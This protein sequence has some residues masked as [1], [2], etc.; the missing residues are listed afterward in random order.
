MPNMKITG[1]GKPTSHWCRPS[2]CRSGRPPSLNNIQKEK[3][4]PLYL[5]CVR[6][7]DKY[8]GVKF[9]LCR[10]WAATNFEKK[11]EFSSSQR[12]Y[13]P[14]T[15]NTTSYE[16]QT[17]AFSKIPD[18]PLELEVHQYLPTYT[19]YNLHH[20]SKTFQEV[21]G[22]FPEHYFYH[23]LFIW[24]TQESFPS[25]LRNSLWIKCKDENMEHTNIVLHAME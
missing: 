24:R 8:F 19:I 25:P 20:G 9:M 16:T 1:T 11:K 21:A 7:A 4:E 14:D 23:T 15:S 22:I 3:F 17:S 10:H 12:H 5:C 18:K 13:L 6:N 2:D